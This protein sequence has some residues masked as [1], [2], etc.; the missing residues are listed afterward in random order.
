MRRFQVAC[1]R[2]ALCLAAAL[3]ALAAPS[4]ERTV[5]VADSRRYTGVLGWWTNLYNESHV[6]LA[7]ATVVII[8]TLGYIMGKLTE[9]LLSRLG[10]NLKS[11]VLAEH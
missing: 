9:F 3:P 4:G 1:T 8:P 7:V 5:L 11:R 2:A 10:I 6:L